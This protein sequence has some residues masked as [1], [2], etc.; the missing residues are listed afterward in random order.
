[1]REVANRSHAWPGELRRGGGFSGSLL[2]PGVYGGARARPRSGSVCAARFAGSESPG[3]AAAGSAAAEP[4][5]GEDGRADR[6]PTDGADRARGLGECGAAGRHIVDEDG[7]ALDKARRS[8]RS[9]GKSAP[10]V[11]CALL[12][13]ETDLIGHVPLMA[14]GWKH[15]RCKAER[16][17]LASGCAGHAADRI[18]AATTCR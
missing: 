1:M 3:F 18:L 9:Y 14:K 13:C 17:H 12:M 7:R 2:L 5:G 11:L 16:A 15:V 6:S 10:E 8:G 4:G